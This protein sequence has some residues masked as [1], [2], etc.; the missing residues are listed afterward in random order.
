MKKGSARRSRRRKKKGGEDMTTEGED[1][2]DEAYTEQDAEAESVMTLEEE[3]M[4][5]IPAEKLPAPGDNNDDDNDNLLLMDSNTIYKGVLNALAGGTPN[6]IG[7][8]IRKLRQLQQKQ[9]TSVSELI[10]YSK[11]H[12]NEIQPNTLV[13]D[14]FPAIFQLTR[15]AVLGK[16]KKTLG[17]TASDD[18]DEKNKDGNDEKEEGDG[19]SDMEMPSTPLAT[20]AVESQSR[21]EERKESNVVEEEEEEE[22][23]AEDASALVWLVR[24][25]EGTFGASSSSRQH[26]KQQQQQQQQTANNAEP[27][28]RE[29]EIRLDEEPGREWGNVPESLT[30]CVVALHDMM[31]PLLLNGGI[32]SVGTALVLE[33]ISLLCEAYWLHRRPGAERAVALTLH[34]L[35]TKIVASGSQL[36][37]AAPP[38][39]QGAA[40]VRRGDVHRA[41]QMRGAFRKIDFGDEDSTSSLRRLMVRAAIMPGVVR[42]ADG[43]GLVASFLTLH[44]A[45]L[46]ELHQAIKCQLRGGRKWQT[47]KYAAIYFRAWRLAMAAGAGGPQVLTAL[48]NDCIQDLMSLAVHVQSTALSNTLARLLS[49]FHKHKPQ[50]GV[51]EMLCRLYAPIL[52]RSLSVANPLVRRNAAVLFLDA[53]PVQDPAGSQREIEEAIQAQCNTF[54]AL[55]FDPYEGVRKVAVLGVARALSLYWELIPAATTARLL[56][57]IEDLAQDRTSPAVRAAVFDGLGAILENSLAHAA[58]RQLLGKLAPAIHDTSE[59]VRTAFVALLIAIKPYRAFK[60]YEIVPL[61]DLVY[62]LAHETKPLARR[63]ATLLCETYFPTD[64]SSALLKRSLILLRESPQAAFSF[65]S[66]LV[67][68]DVPLVSICK[69]IARAFLFLSKSALEETSDEPPAK[70]RKEQQKKG[71]RKAKKRGDDDNDVE[72][73]EEEESRNRDEEKEENDNKELLSNLFRVTHILYTGISASLHEDKN[74]ELRGKLEEVVMWGSLHAI[75]AFIGTPLAKTIAIGI[76][77]YIDPPVEKSEVLAQRKLTADLC[78]L[79]TVVDSDEYSTLLKYLFSQRGSGEAVLGQMITMLSP[80]DDGATTSTGIVDGYGGSGT[81]VGCNALLGLQ[82]LDKILSVR[83]VREMAFEYHSQIVKIL[84][85]LRSLVSIA[86]DRVSAGPLSSEEEDDGEDDDDDNGESG[87]SELETVL[88]LAVTYYAKLLI[89]FIAMREVGGDPSDEPEEE[90]GGEEGGGK[91]DKSVFARDTFCGL[92]RWAYNVC[93]PQAMRYGGMCDGLVRGVAVIS[94][95]LVVVGLGDETLID[96]ISELYRRCLAAV[97]GEDD[98]ETNDFASELLPHISK[99]IYHLYYYDA[100]NRGPGKYCEMSLSILEQVLRSLPLS[101]LEKRLQIQD[102]INTQSA[103]G[104]LLHFSEFLTELALESVPD[105]EILD[106]DSF[107]KEKTVGAAG[108][109]REE[110]EDGVDKK[111]E[112]RISKDATMYVGKLVTRSSLMMTQVFNVLMDKV[113][114][115]EYSPQCLWKALNFSSF[116]VGRIE[117]KKE[118]RVGKR[119]RPSEVSLVKEF[120][121]KIFERLSQT[122]LENSYELSDLTEFTRRLL[123]RIIDINSDKTN[124]PEWSSN[125]NNAETEE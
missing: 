82:I 57:Q 89:H 62:C 111:K 48:E 80:E 60:F 72:E 40:G 32:S 64:S 24:A 110:Q 116:V 28:T 39:S 65:Y 4:E 93:L 71:R 15:N 11:F 1:E 117:E 105:T 107:W 104:T 43:F 10:K 83:E 119:L 56:S 125:D 96:A 38:S 46:E 14:E 106:G 49:F 27:Q 44:V 76:G 25:L 98:A 21:H 122:T 19:D 73:D 95:E 45:L 2:E 26:R 70:K 36:P 100:G 22:F 34:Y 29:I 50:Q 42:L 115:S 91:G 3:E 79:Q 8:A 12:V 69:F 121:T 47:D 63:L 54:S 18:D 124:N 109:E 67:D 88:L 120:L 123:N 52:W 99:F 108:G 87:P 84:K 102:V 53:F 92:V 35:M 81:I 30:Q 77:S 33:E 55:L 41:F 17:G 112:K 58:L 68:M 5:A 9:R 61:Q 75:A 78:N 74:K 13:E 51:D 23:S 114:K 16:L 37:I 6:E 85:T 90:A 101:V 103:G 118:R 20:G 94:A 66:N 7:E 59:K 97:A 86:M 31:Y 113:E